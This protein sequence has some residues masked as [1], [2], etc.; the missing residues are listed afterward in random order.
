MIQEGELLF[1]L[2]EEVLKYEHLPVLVQNWKNLD[3]IPAF[4]HESDLRRVE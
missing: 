3:I 4:A 2:M 1:Q